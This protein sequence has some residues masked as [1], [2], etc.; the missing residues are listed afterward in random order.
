MK[1]EGKLVKNSRKDI[2]KLE[3][4]KRLSSI[5]KRRCHT[6]TERVSTVIKEDKHEIMQ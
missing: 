5:K 3:S 2:T 4:S 6:L 1:K